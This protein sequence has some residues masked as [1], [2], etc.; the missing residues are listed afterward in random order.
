MSDK[1]KKIYWDEMSAKEMEIY[2]VEFFKCHYCGYSPLIWS[3][4]IGD[5]VCESCGKWQNGK[6]RK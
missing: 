1:K 5:S 2:D 6:E 3:M 4:A